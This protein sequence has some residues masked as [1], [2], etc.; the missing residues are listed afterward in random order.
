MHLCVYRFEEE[1]Q[2]SVHALVDHFDQ[3]RAG[4]EQES[5]CQTF[6]LLSYQNTVHRFLICC[7][8]FRCSYSWSRRSYSLYREETGPTCLCGLASTN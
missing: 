2:T 8:N 7:G 5:V 6:C 4:E 3:P 1:Y